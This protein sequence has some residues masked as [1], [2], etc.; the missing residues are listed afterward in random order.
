MSNPETPTAILP[1]NSLINPKR[2]KLPKRIRKRRRVLRH[3][4]R[5]SRRTI[6]HL[7]VI[8]RLRRKLPAQIDIDN[9][10][11]VPEVTGDVAL[12]TGEVG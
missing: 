8:L 4:I 9:D 2:R 3:E 5:T 6:I 11:L 12:C 10:V 7:I 1:L